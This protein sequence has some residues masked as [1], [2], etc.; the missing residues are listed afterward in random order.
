MP[1]Y[2]A[3]GANMDVAAMAVRCPASRPIGQARLP[4]HRFIVTRDGFASVLRDPRREVHGVLWE[5][6]LSDI[7]TLDKFEEV[8]RGLYAKII[9]PVLVEGG[10][11]RALVYVGCTSFVGKPK[12]G[13]L[14][15]VLASA[16]HW[17][18]PPGYVAEMARFLGRPR[19][20]K[21]AEIQPA[22]TR[23]AVTPTAERPVTTLGMADR[24]TSQW[25][26][27]A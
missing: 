19:E 13:Y 21:A 5:A 25:R 2:F 17:Q 3:Y 12:P 18:F 6:A 24:A 20:A 9:Q 14:E 23:P 22:A 11:R 27:G 7:R 26:W 16:E 15:A 1:L 4:R 8:D 10:T